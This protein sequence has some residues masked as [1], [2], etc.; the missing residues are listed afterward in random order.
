[1]GKTIRVPSAVV[2]AVSLASMSA[3]G[4]TTFCLKNKGEVLFG[5]NYDWAIGDGAIFVNRRGVAKTSGQTTDPARWTSKFGSVTFDQYGWESPSGG[6]NEAGLVIELMWLDDTQYPEASS[7]PS[8]DV[9]E[10]I[11]YQLD[12]SETTADVIR[13]AAKVRISSPVR[14][15]YMVNDASGNSA[16]IE[17]LD[18]K[19]V[20]HTGDQLPVA[21]LTNDT[22]AH[23]IEFAA[24]NS[25]ANSAG[26]GS[27]QR[28]VRASSKAKVFAAK[29]RSESEAVAYAFDILDDAAQ[30]GHTQWSI[31]Y[32]QRNRLIHYRTRAARETRTIDTKAFNYDCGAPLLMLDVDRGSGDVTRAFTPYTRAANRDLIERAFNGTPFLKAVPAAARDGYAER[33]EHFACAAAAR[34]H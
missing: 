14:L 24:K 20:V 8:I 26:V 1:M 9:L 12:T 3:F 32:D 25:V 16:T 10:W 33:P 30:P 22:Y 31:V 2:L 4:C 7:L 19:L 27:L 6:M 29:P 15:H 17:F 34:S 13:N 21:T 18:G 23:S 5:K 28:F 11:Q